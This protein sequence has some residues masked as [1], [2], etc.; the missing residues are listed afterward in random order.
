[1]RFIWFLA[2]RH[3][4]YRRTQ[5]LITLLGV[6]VGIMVLTTAL[7]LTNG[8]IRGLLDSS[9]KG[10]PHV[11]LQV[12][13]PQQ[14][15]PPPAHPEVLAQTPYLVTK[16]LITRRAEAGRRA[17]VDVATVWGLGKDGAKVYP[18]LGLDKL[19][20][21]KM[22]LGFALAR[23]LGAFPGDKVFLVSVNQQR[24]SLE[25]VGTFEV[26][27]ALIDMGNA[28]V[29]IAEVRQLMQDPKGLSGY[30]LLLQ[31]P[32]RARTV[33]YELSS[34][35]GEP[36]SYF[37]Q[38]WQDLF[39]TLIAQLALQKRV[40][41]IV[42]FLI[43]CVAA[44]GMANVLV[45]AIVEKTPDIA[46]LRVLGA[47]AKQVA[48]VFALEGLLLGAAGI[49]VGNLLGYGLSSYFVHNPV[50]IPGELYFLTGLAA[51]IKPLDFVWVSLMSLLVVLLASLLPLLRALRVKPGEVLR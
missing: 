34:K 49:L 4:R 29:D 38:T 26:G 14:A 22:V 10:V 33:G 50:R 3:L 1:V 15:S 31:N 48:G 7:S 28:F 24:I 51:Q 30:Q 44:L 18:S 17:G 5:S 35:P 36:L 45:L 2:L 19:G 41:G 6:A 46:L 8:F 27:N 11:I 9:I 23:Q 47:G 13:D 37:A 32:E 21:G 40:I 43:V 12:L 25:V 42:I 39:R 16:A 20:P